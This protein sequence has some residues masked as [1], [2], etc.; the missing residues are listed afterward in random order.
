MVDTFEVRR[1]F[2]SVAFLLARLGSLVELSGDLLG[3]PS[4]AGSYPVVEEFVNRGSGLGSALGVLYPLLLESQA[5]FRSIRGQLRGENMGLE[6]GLGDLEGGSS[7]NVVEEETGIVAITTTPSRVPSSSHSPVPA[8]ARRFH[9]LKENCSLKVE[10]F[11][12]FKDRFQFPEGTKARLPRKGEKACAFAHGEV[13]FYEAAFSCGL[14]FPVH[15]FIM[16][17]L[18]HFN[19]APGQI[20]PNSWR[21]VIS[22]MVI[23][24]T[25][26]DGDMI[27]VN[28][29]VYLY[30]LKES[31]EFGYYEFVP[32]SRKARL[33]ADLPS[34]F[35][36]WK[37][38]YFFVSGDGWETLPD[39]L[40]GNVPRLLRRWETPLI[41]KDRPELE[42]RFAKRVQAALEYAR[43]IEDFGEL[44]DPRTLARHC[45]GPEPSLYVLKMTSK[46]NKEM[47]AKIKGKKNEPLSS[48]G[49]KRLRITDREKEKEVVERGSSTP[50]LDLDEGLLASPGVSIEEVARPSKKQKAASKG[51]GKADASVW[52]DAGTAMDRAT[53]LFTPAEM[54]EVTSIP[55]HE[56]VSRHVHKLV[57]VLGETMHITTQYLANEEKAVVANS[58]VD[59]LEAEASGLRKDLI[60]TMDSLN[61][62]KEQV[63][64]LTEQLDSERQTVKQKDELLATAAQKMKVAVAKAVTAFQSSEE[65]NTLLFQWYFKGFE[66]LRRYLVK[67]GP[68]VSLDDLDFEAVDKEIE[69]DEAAQ[70]GVSTGVEP[71]QATQDDEIPPSA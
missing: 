16:E 31:R 36:Y 25:I 38:R 27:S 4:L 61:A 70:T 47:Y 7:S 21:I 13:C 51:K 20:M 50:T 18:Y 37:S 33:V 28:E 45:L 44:I 22:C 9:A 59:A 46:F 43:T 8:T 29:F 60:T 58:K 67:H 62:S 19:L 68:V 55:S 10:V 5:W 3:A 49:Q 71:P 39:D 69:E 23:W 42:A 66:L 24:T 48:I 34:S 26:A 32:W 65:Y 53:E 54:R 41:V 64:V 11:S 56:M 14:R 17:L 30:R 1:S 12:K 2:P 35:R 6:E 52:S 15:P 40:W 63:R 57:Q